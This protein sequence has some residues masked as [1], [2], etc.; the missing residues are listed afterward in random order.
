MRALWEAAAPELGLD[1][2]LV[3]EAVE[4]AGGN[5]QHAEMLRKHLASLPPEQRRVEA[6]RAASGR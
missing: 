4:R 2:A 1:A 5:P 3:A 6:I